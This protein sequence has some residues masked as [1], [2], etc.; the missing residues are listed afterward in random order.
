MANKQPNEQTP[1]RPIATAAWLLLSHTFLSLLSSTIGST[2]GYAV[3]LLSYLVPVGMYVFFVRKRGLYTAFAPTRVGCARVLP[4]LPL[5]L[6]AVMMVSTLTVEVMTLLGL[7][8]SGG[9]AEGNGFFPDLL[10]DCLAPAFL[11]EGLMRFAVLSLL[12]MWNGRHAVW[13]SAALFALQHASLY[14]APYA[15]VG[16]FFLALAVVWGETPVFAFAFH[17][18]NNLLSLFLQ[19]CAIW[20]GEDVGLWISLGVWFVLFAAG[21]IGFLTLWRRGELRRRANSEPTNWREL[22]YSPLTAWAA[23]MLIFTI[24]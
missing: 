24:L 9:M 20:W 5:F 10:T 19:Y 18:L 11:E 7:P 22:I 3:Y 15:F 8:M 12:L 6:C 2:G 17:F 23:M 4:L 16:G 21:A 14:Q 1:V 13:V